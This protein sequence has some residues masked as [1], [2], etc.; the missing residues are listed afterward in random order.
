M[1]VN[2]DNK[3]LKGYV[4]HKSG[5]AGGLLVGKR[6]SEGGI[7]VVNKS[8]GSPLEVE[9]GE[10]I[11]TRPAVADETKKEFEGQMLTNREILSKINSDAGGVAFAEGGAIPEH[12]ATKGASYKYGGKTMRDYEIVADC[13]CK[14]KMEGGGEVQP[15]TL[16]LIHNKEKAPYLGKR[17]GQ[18]VEPAGY[19]AIEKPSTFTGATNYDVV[20]FQSKK[21]LYIPVTSDT[22]VSW[23]YELSKK[24]K[25]KKKELTNKLMSEGYDAIIT[26]YA[27]GDTGE[28]IILD[29]DRIKIAYKSDGKLEVGKLSKGMNLTD[30]AEMHGMKEADLKEEMRMGIKHEMTEHTN[31]K[32]AAMRIALDHLVENPRYYTDL[33][34]F[35]EQNAP[36]YDEHFDAI[37]ITMAEGGE[38]SA[39]YSFKTPTGEPSKLTYVQQVL[40]R[41]KAFKQYFGDWETAA[42]RYLLDKQEN[43]HAHYEN[44]SK[45][46][47]FGTLE[48][49]V[50]YHGTMAADEF[51]TFDVTK[52]QGVGRPYAYFA[53]NKEYAENFNKFSQRGEAVRSLLYS[54]FLNIRKPFMARGMEYEQ[55]QKDAGYWMTII[56]GTIT[57]DRYGD[58]S[59]RDELDAAVDSQIK[60]YVRDTYTQPAPFWWLMARDTNKEFKYFLM[61]YGYDGVAFS[62]EY[63]ADYDVTNPSQFTYAYTVFDATQIKLADGRNIDFDAMNPDIRYERGGK[64]LN[65]G[66]MENAEDRAET[67]EERRRRLR[68]MCLGESAMSKGGDIF[69][70]GGEIH[71]DKENLSTFDRSSRR[72][73]AVEYVD[74]LIARTKK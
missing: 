47:D 4:T 22:L 23:K 62:E 46:I 56:K 30:V 18:D 40:V 43:F 31:D 34:K 9:G 74:G 10:V 15:I 44:V 72:S 41:T 16:R 54:S 17:F 66:K 69:K 61:S 53:V 12:V 6:H 55:K 26:K 70:S 29:T 60:G 36:S 68:E 7:K 37:V 48:P 3:Y 32:T 59:K 73:G 50:V 14:H 45:I 52:E 38:V 42:K 58:L 20:E 2:P 5:A 8:N 13:G 21:P 49:K 27:E 67:K 51:F 57:F 65:E 24:Y 11:I 71:T 25:S 1:A 63:T 64:I 19:Y 33:Q 28:I 39:L 35:E